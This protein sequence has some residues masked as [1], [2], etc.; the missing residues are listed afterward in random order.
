MMV[1]P[2]NWHAGIHRSGQPKIL[3]SNP[4]VAP[5]P[6]ILLIMSGEYHRDIIIQYVYIYVYVYIILYNITSNVYTWNHQHPSSSNNIRHHPPTKNFFKHPTLWEA[7]GSSH[8]ACWCIC[9]GFA[10]T[11]WR[12]QHDMFLS[13]ALNMFNSLKQFQTKQNQLNQLGFSHWNFNFQVQ[14]RKGREK[15]CHGFSKRNHLRHFSGAAWGHFSGPFP[16]WSVLQHSRWSKQ[17]A[18]RWS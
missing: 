8:I 11:S 6:F 12:D 10:S 5:Q 13:N 9:S 14:T 17:S 15:K 1:D 3:L 7:F 18:Q 4:M 2:K 16:L